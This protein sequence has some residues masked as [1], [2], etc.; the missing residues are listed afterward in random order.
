LLAPATRYNIAVNSFQKQ[1]DSM[2]NQADNALIMIYVLTAVIVISAIVAV[3][4]MVR[5]SR[6]SQ[7]MTRKSTMNI[8]D[9]QDAK[10]N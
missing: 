6:H 9:N 8:E 7:F 3:H 4:I 5:K 1:P 2:N 10:N